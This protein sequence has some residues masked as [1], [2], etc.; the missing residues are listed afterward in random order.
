MYELNS[1]RVNFQRP[2]QQIT[3]VTQTL[4]PGLSRVSSYIVFQIILSQ[5]IHES[6][7]TKVLQCTTNA[8]GIQNKLPLYYFL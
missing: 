3:F 8:I 4:V 5:G 7:K 2:L 1:F 6:L